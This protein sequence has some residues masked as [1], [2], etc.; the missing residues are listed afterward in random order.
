MGFSDL[1]VRSMGSA[2]KLELTGGQLERAAMLRQN[3][4]CALKPYY[5]SVY[6]DL[7]ER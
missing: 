1:R 6:L 3:V 4:I 2:A 5:D 7:K